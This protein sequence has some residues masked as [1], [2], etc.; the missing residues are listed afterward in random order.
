MKA[1]LI[2]TLWIEQRQ[3]YYKFI[4]MSVQAFKNPETANK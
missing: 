3:S 4:A 2:R 1:Q